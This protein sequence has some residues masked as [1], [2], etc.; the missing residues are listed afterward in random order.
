[1]RKFS[2]RVVRLPKVSGKACAQY[3]G[4][5][6]ATRGQKLGL[7]HSQ[8]ATHSNLGISSLSKPTLY[9]NCM[10]VIPVLMGKF[11]SVNQQFCTVYTGPITTT[12]TLF[13]KRGTL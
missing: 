6:W 10:Q 1:M 13:N 4:S 9:T 11:T 3:V 7:L 8:L 5:L 12:T 2:T